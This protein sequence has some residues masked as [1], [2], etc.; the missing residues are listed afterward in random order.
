MLTPTHIRALITPTWG[1]ARADV[2]LQLL[3]GSDEGIHAEGVPFQGGLRA[4]CTYAAPVH[5]VRATLQPWHTCQK[6]RW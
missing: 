6:H 2:M 3:H 4:G 1:V 5:L